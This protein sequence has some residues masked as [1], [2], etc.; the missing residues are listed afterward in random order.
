MH[1]SHTR[2]LMTGTNESQMPR[3][4][5]PP[6]LYHIFLALKK[7]LSWYEAQQKMS[8]KYNLEN[9]SFTPWSGWLN[10]LVTELWVLPFPGCGLESCYSIDQIISNVKQ[11]KQNCKMLFILKNSP[12][13]SWKRISHIICLPWTL[14]HSHLWKYC[15]KNYVLKQLL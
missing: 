2:N 8:L 14:L 6:S 9:S 12:Q 3:W 11:T 13:S 7:C 4:N 1:F 5:F 15:L 10:I